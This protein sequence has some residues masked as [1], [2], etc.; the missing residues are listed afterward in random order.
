MSRRPNRP[1]RAVSKR[2]INVLRLAGWRYSSTRDA[3]VHRIGEG[4][5]RPVF[6]DRDMV[7][8][9]QCTT[10]TRIFDAM[11]AAKQPKIVPEHERTPLPRRAVTEE[12]PITPVEV[13]LAAEEAPR[14]VQVDG[15]PPARGRDP[16]SLRPTGG[17]VVPI[18]SAR[19]TA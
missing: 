15:R 4:R 9:G 6:R 11:M 19:A 2:T 14:I 18:K 13:Q 17:V 12:R 16:R 3:W 1:R 10:D 8:E 7:D 5:I